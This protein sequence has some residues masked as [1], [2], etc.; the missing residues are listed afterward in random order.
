MSYAL[1]CCENAEDH[2]ERGKELSSQGLYVEAI[3]EYRQAVALDQ[4]YAEPLNNIGASY[5]HMELYDS[6]LYYY[7]KAIQIVPQYSRAWNNKGMVFERF[8]EYDSALECYRKSIHYFD[9]PAAYFNRGDLNLKLGKN[10]AALLDINET[11]ALGFREAKCYER[12]GTIKFN[13]GD[14]Q[15]ALN[16]YNESIRIDSLY[17]YSYRH[18]AS[19]KYELED[20]EGAFEDIAKAIELNP[21]NIKNWLE[22]VRLL[23]KEKEY[24]QAISDLNEVLV[25]DSL[26]QQ[27]YIARAESNVFLTN[28]DD[29]LTDA[30]KGSEL[31]TTPYNLNLIGII[32]I[33][34]GKFQEAIEYYDRAISMDR[35]RSKSYL[36]RAMAHGKMNKYAMALADLDKAKSL[37]LSEYNILGEKIEM[38]VIT[39]LIGNVIIFKK[40]LKN[41][42]EYD[43]FFDGFMS[44]VFNDYSTGRSMIDEAYNMDRDNYLINYFLGIIEMHIGDKNP[45][46]YFEKAAESN[47]E[48]TLETYAE[49][50]G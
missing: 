20:L 32:L 25:R 49:Q 14:L 4:K 2:Y 31:N 17:E 10:E 24:E 1:F 6:S 37:G 16:A 45:C 50:C 26:Y 34:L 33:R 23:K 13:L 8:E 7:N 27:A 40:Q 22:R 12:L 5:Y 46:Q 44:I 28:Y 15:G 38:N 29:A 11:I 35:M 19:L 39:E 36:N 30:L 18:R 3:R 48:F 42:K 43:I 47:W 41:Q 21:G 9:L